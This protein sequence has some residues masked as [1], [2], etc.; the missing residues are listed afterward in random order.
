MKY[1]PKYIKIYFNNGDEVGFGCSKVELDVVS[2]SIK[3]NGK[4]KYTDPEE[5]H[6]YPLSKI[7][8]VEI[9]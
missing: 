2:Q 3:V 9:D 6:I 1:I 7:T 4:R 5:L 8:R